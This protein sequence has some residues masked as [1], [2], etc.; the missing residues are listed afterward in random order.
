MRPP[1]EEIRISKRSKEVLVKLRRQTKIETWNQI[2]RIAYCRSLSFPAQT[3]LKAIGETAIRMDWRTFAGPY[4][5]VFCCLSLIRARN[6]GV[7]LSSREAVSRH[8]HHMLNSGIQNLGAIR[9]LD[10]LASAMCQSNLELEIGSIDL[11]DAS[12]VDER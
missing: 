5:Q 2:C 10:E 6:D 8:F 7:E 12:Q 3:E 1:V 11:T 9:A 4:S